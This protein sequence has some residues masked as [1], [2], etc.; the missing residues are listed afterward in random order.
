MPA[1]VVTLAV[2][3]LSGWLNAS[4]YCPAKRRAFTVGGMCAGR[5]ERVG[6][7]RCKERAGEGL[8]G[9]H[10]V[11]G[12]GGAHVEHDFHGGDIGRVEAQRLVDLFRVLPSRKEGIQG[13]RRV[14][15]QAR[16]CGPVAMRG[17]GGR[18]AEGRPEGARLGPSAHKTWTPWW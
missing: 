4:A 5:R 8:K 14:G 2:L 6:W 9:D 18:G 17:M 10:G 1:M 11:R 3:K 16:A 12:T 13:R 7:L 15:W